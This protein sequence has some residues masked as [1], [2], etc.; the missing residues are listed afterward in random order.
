MSFLVLI[1]HISRK[2]PL[3]FHQKAFLRDIERKA[4]CDVT[5]DMFRCSSATN[6]SEKSESVELSSVELLRAAHVHV[7]AELLILAQNLWQV[8]AGEI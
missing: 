2:R 3:C 1:Y 4:N 8:Q 7:R 5:A 6:V